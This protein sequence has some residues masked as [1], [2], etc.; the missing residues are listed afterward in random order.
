[1]LLSFP[2]MNKSWQSWAPFQSPPMREICAHLTAAEWNKIQ[3][4]GAL[5]GIWV[6]ATAAEPFGYLLVYRNPF[7]MGLAGMLIAL[8]VACI[9]FWRRRM[10][11]LLCETVWAQEHGFTPEQI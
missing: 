8:H 1:V 4:Q 3:G 11:R 6:F 5:Y 2:P 9:P 7:L 10:K